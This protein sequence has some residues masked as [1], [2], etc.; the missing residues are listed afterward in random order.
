[1]DGRPSWTSKSRTPGWRYHFIAKG[2]V[3]VV[4]PSFRETKTTAERGRSS[5][6]H[7]RSYPWNIPIGNQ[8]LV[9]P[10]SKTHLPPSLEPIAINNNAIRFVPFN[11]HAC[12]RV[13]SNRDGSAE[14]LMAAFVEDDEPV[15]HLG[16]ESVIPL[17]P[18]LAKHPP[19]PREIVGLPGNLFAVYFDR[20]CP[21]E[22]HFSLQRARSASK[23]VPSAATWTRYI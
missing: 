16:L 3:S 8:H 18:G 22:K 11:D 19:P 5:S 23:S 6:Q 17:R 20:P 13:S 9:R 2:Q 12:V 10:A 15:V 7:K 21:S 14:D 4:C 1:M